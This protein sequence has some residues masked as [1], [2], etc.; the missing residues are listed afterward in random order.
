[1][2]HSE[3]FIV[4]RR[5]RFSNVL[6][7]NESEKISSDLATVHGVSQVKV[8]SNQKVIDVTYDLCEAR[9]E[10]IRQRVVDQGFPLIGGLFTDWKN[11]WVTYQEENARLN[12]NTPGS[13]C[14]SKPPP[15]AGKY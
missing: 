7:E 3:G 5:L 12:A 15:G 11:A 14:C 9:W 6:S 10:K 1:M 4:T 2:N 13:P 8:A